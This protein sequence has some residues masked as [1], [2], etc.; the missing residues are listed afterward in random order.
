MFKYSD[1][2]YDQ[3]Y[4]S[5]HCEKENAEIK[6]ILN[7]VCGEGHWIADLGA[8]T[9]LCASLIGGNNV[10]LQIEKDVK[11]LS[12]NPYGHFVNMDAFSYLNGNCIVPDYVVSLFA[13]NYMRIGTISLAVE[14]AKKACV[15]VLYDKPYKTG[16]SSY[17]SGKKLHFLLKHFV[18]SVIIRAEIKMMQLK[19]RKVK[20][21]NL[22]GEPYYKV[23]ILS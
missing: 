16:S 17:Y 4:S 2:D 7:S 3:F 23:V 20:K 22:L 14:K 10:V 1:L 21:W 13:V 5:E 9:G 6:K 18:K 15:F 19:G 11:M 12:Q 8:G